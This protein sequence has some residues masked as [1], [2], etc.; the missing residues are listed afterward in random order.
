M[1][2]ATC[3]PSKKMVY[4]FPINAP[5]SVLNVGGYTVGTNLNFAVNKGFLIVA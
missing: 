1:A 4:N 3:S 5:M 2:N